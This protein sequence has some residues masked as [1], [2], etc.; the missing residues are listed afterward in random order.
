MKQPIHH[1]RQFRL[2]IG[3]VEMAVILA[4]IALVAFF[5]I[6]Q[7]GSSVSADLN[8][9]ASGVGDP[10][11]LVHHS[12]FTGQYDQNGGDT[13]DN[14]GDTADDGSGGTSG[15]DTSG[16]GDSGSGGDSGWGGGSGG[17]GGGDGGGGGGF[18]GWVGG[19]F[20]W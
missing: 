10:A 13:A 1:K 8:Q 14:G 15:G 12:R 19:W 2:G 20:G 3:L 11:Q 4:A 5:G 18:W 6:S 7:L 9:T 16:G 17:G